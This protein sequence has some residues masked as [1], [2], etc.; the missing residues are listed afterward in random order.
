MLYNI[1]FYTQ[2]A[3][4]YHPLVDFCIIYNHIAAFF[5]FSFSSLERLWYLSQAF[6]EVF[7]FYFDDIYLTRSFYICEKKFT[8]SLLEDI[9]MLQVNLILICVIH[10]HLG[11]FK[12]TKILKCFLRSIANSYFLKK[13]FFPTKFNDWISNCFE[14]KT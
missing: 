2:Q 6:F 7:R 8:K 12:I 4:V 13:Q 14:K 10:K 3:F 11:L 5:F 1:F 9:K